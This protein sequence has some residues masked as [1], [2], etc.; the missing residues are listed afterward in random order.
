VGEKAETRWKKA[1]Q[2]YNRKHPALA[3]AWVNALTRFMPKGWEANLPQF[4]PEDGPMATRAAS[5]KV[6]NAAA[7][8]FPSLMGG[9]A[10]LAPSNK[11]FIDGSPE[12]QKNHYDGRNIRFGVREFAMGAIMS[13]MFLHGGVR[14]YG[15]TFL[16]F[17]D[18]MRPSIRLA[19]L[20][21]LPVVY[22]FT[23]DSVA[24]GEDGPTHQPVEHLAALRAIPNLTIIRP[25]DATETAQAWH[26]AIAMNDSPVALVL[27]RQKLPILDSKQTAHGVE[28]GGYVLSNCKGKPRL[29]LIATGAEVILPFRRRQSWPARASLPGWSACRPGS[30]SKKIPPSLK[31][32]F[33]RRPSSTG[34]PLKPAF[35]WGGSVTSARTARSSASI[36]TAPRHQAERF[37]KNSV[38]RRIRSLRPQ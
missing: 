11:T 27:S 28:Q 19:A 32:A 5:G 23:H 29:L 18:Y 17:A 14:P 12:F 7:A 13:G 24:V 26:R 36:G 38:L 34:S 31:T 16:V 9:S 2:K 21:K 25:A 15:G 22:V 4:K 1:Y 35:P 6:L 20:M 37:W 8:I 10:D 30:F 33:C 3:D